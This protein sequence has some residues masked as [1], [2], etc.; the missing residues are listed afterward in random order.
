MKGARRWTSG[1]C[2]FMVLPLHRELK[3][4]DLSPGKQP[5]GSRPL[6]NLPSVGAKWG[7]PRHTDKVTLQFSTQSEAFLLRSSL[8][9][10]RMSLSCNFTHEEAKGEII[11]DDI[12]LFSE[13]Q[14]YS[15]TG[16]TF[17]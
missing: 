3:V 13:N 10:M 15:E 16:G 11:F 9:N 4:G 1:L 5:H 14:S 7:S 17:L 12:K 8:H 6:S 2:T